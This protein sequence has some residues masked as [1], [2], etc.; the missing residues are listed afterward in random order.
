MG[1]SP[2]YHLNSFEATVTGNGELSAAFG[3]V[4]LEAVELSV[5]RRHAY[6]LLLVPKMA[7]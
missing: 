1:L 6:G 2:Y 5:R 4:Q 3:A 7:L